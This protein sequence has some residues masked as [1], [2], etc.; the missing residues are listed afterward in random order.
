MHAMIPLDLF[1]LIHGQRRI[2]Q[3]TEQVVAACREQVW[4]KVAGRAG[5]LSPAEARGYV[6]ARAAIAVREAVE[7]TAEE[8]QLSARLRARLAEQTLSRVVSDLSRQL[9][10]A[11]PLRLRR[12]A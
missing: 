2:D 1:G 11:A 7:R 6:R 5:R 4:A 10:P 9:V 3:L 8:N 12:A